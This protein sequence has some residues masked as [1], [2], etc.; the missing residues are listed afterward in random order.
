M[1]VKRTDNHG[2]IFSNISEPKLITQ[3][4]KWLISCLERYL[5]LV[6]GIYST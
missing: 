2:E 5:V 1:Y 6:A 4:L 3:F